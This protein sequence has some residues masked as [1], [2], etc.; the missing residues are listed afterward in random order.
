MALPLA[1][2][3]SL[4]LTLLSFRHTLMQHGP[5]TTLIVALS[6]LIVSFL[7]PPWLLGKPKSRQQF[8]IQ[9]LRLSWGLWQ[10]WQLR[11]PGSGGY[12]R[13]SVW[14]LAHQ[15]LSPLV[16]SIL[17]GILWSMNSTSTSM[18]MLLTWDRSVALQY[19]PSEFQLSDFFTKAQTKAQHSY[20]LSKLSVVD[21][22]W[23]CR[24]VLDV[25]TSLCI[26]S[27]V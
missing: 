5:V 14:W 2:C 22:P 15:L 23:V 19:V 6:L 18:L 21:P 9:V 11:S 26:S 4:V 1:S 12:L 27:L 24:G 10:Q 16:R 25:Y 7:G 13:I 20:F 3:C 17:L 8:L